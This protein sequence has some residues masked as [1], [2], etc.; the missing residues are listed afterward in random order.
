[1]S[2][3]DQLVAFNQRDAGH[4]GASGTGPR[5]STRVAIVTCM[6]ARIDPAA[7]LG[8]G[9]GDAHVIRNAGALVSGDVLRSLLISQHELGTTEVMLVAHTGCGMLSIDANALAAEV[10]R[11]T[12]AELDVDLGAFGDLEAHVREGI[13]RIRET[14]PLPHRDHVRGFIL[15]VVSGRLSEVR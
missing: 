11:R 10:R 2:G 7:L 14:Q 15:D 13:A 12:G 4:H 5:P 6:D 8:I 9:P 1:M 3:I